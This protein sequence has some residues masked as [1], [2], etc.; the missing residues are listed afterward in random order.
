[1]GSY[2]NLRSCLGEP[3]HKANDC[4]RRSVKPRHGRKTPAIEQPSRERCG[5]CGSLVR[6]ALQGNQPLGFERHKYPSS[7]LW[8]ESGTQ[9][10]KAVQAKRAHR[11]KS[12][13]TV[14]GGLPTLGGS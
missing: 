8:C 9:P 12:V 6:V 14:Q 1:M 4:P 2:C 7:S 3:V 10:V 11:G 5:T 13:R